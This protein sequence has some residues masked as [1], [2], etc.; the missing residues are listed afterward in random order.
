MKQSNFL[1]PAIAGISR[2]LIN[3]RALTL[4]FILC[5][6]SLFAAPPAITV[7]S[8][9]PTNIC[10][11][12]SST[13]ITVKFTTSN[14]TAGTYTYTVQLSGSNGTFTSPTTIGTL[15][16]SALNQLFTINN[17]TIPGSTVASTS[18]KIRV[19]QSGT[20]STNSVAFSIYPLPT[21]VSG[22]ATTICTGASTTIGASA[23]SGNTYSWVSAP[24]GFSSTLANPTTSPTTTTT[25]T[26]T[27]DSSTGCLASKPVIVTVNPT[28]A[29]AAYTGSPGTICS[30]TSYA[31]GGAPVGGNTY[32]WTSTPS[33]FSSALSTVTVNPTTTTTYT[34]TETAGTCNNSNSVVVSVNP[35]PAAN[36]GS[37]SGI[38]NNGASASIGATS[39]ADDTYSWVSS[40][41]GFTST[42]SSG[43]VSPTITTTYTLTE[44]ITTTGCT[45]SNQN[46]VTVNP[47]PAANV[48][49]I[50]AVCT[51]SSINLGATATVG[52]TYAW[53]STP[54]GFTST[55]SNPSVGPTAVTTYSLTETVT[56]TGC[57]SANSVT[58]SINALPNANAGSNTS[59]TTGSSTSIGATAVNGDTYSWLSNPSGYT[60]MV[61]NPSVDPV[62][63]TTYTLTETIT[64]TGC[65]KSNQ[66]IITV[67]PLPLPVELVNFTSVLQDPETV[68]LDWVTASE[69]N[70]D[71]FIIERSVNSG[72]FIE[73]GRVN[74]NGTTAEEH[75]YTYF[76][77]H[78]DLLAAN[79]L[80]YRLRQ[81]DLNG[82]VSDPGEGVRE[83]TLNQVAKPGTTKLWYNALET[84]IYINLVR[85]S[86]MNASILITDMNGKMIASQ[87]ILTNI[88][89]TQVSL[90]TTGQTK[91]IYMVRINDNTGS[92]STKVVIR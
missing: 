88:G 91:G 79:V 67:N 17:V 62:S 23:V 64:A 22:N 47:L 9:S 60:S 1:S 56:S 81:V 11:S 24:S 65:T 86:A 16:S 68:R 55:V 77:E 27:I 69:S 2:A 66:V 31:I 33:G 51:G 6:G 43:T 18:Y 78:I 8:V 72:A 61:S 83:V 15:S 12:A 28:V 19:Q 58:I 71:Y 29:P 87:N 70:N 36:A 34:L 25:Y 82:K 57:T 49:S 5:A 4:L 21:A 41:S 32:S 13:T 42:A 37:S 73:A 40:P 63:T 53:V 52:N 74:G 50:T 20:T 59:I 48:G 10:F 3:Y 54:S 92:Y 75:D 84:N 46:V 39:V 14:Y 76:D 30:G 26:I 80:Y 85:T 7:N 44:T 89:I 45:K 35:A 90:N 38:C